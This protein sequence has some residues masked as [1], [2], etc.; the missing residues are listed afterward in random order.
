MQ[1]SQA[2]EGDKNSLF[3]TKIMSLATANNAKTNDLTSINDFKTIHS[4]FSSYSRKVVHSAFPTSFP[5][6]FPTCGLGSAGEATRCG[7]CKPG[8][9]TDEHNLRECKLCPLGFYTTEYGAKLC[10]KCTYPWYNL[11]EGSTECAAVYVEMSNT[12]LLLLLGILGAIFLYSLL[13]AD[14]MKQLA[15]TIMIFPSMDI[16]SDMA[17]LLT[18]PF[19]NFWIFMACTLFF[20]LP[21]MI[22]FWMIWEQ[23]ALPFA[24]T[25]F[26][27]FYLGQ[28][29]L[30][31]WLAR[32][33]F[34]LPAIANDTDQDGKHL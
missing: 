12:S 13:H 6:S 18:T 14:E 26:P 1:L 34:G 10:S 20:I 22:F 7:Q 3:Y 17:Y 32:D 15:F 23:G 28:T 33:D 5:T 25:Y 29:K 21:N 31:F 9:Y 27:G 2:V 30:L 19:Y 4:K 24:H 11:N 16:F 8:T